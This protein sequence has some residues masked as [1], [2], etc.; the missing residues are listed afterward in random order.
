MLILN[1]DE[2][3]KGKN[4]LKTYSGE[5]KDY[6]NT[7][8]LRALAS[9]GRSAILLTIFRPGMFSKGH[10]SEHSEFTRFG[11]SDYLILAS[12]EKKEGVVLRDAVAY[13]MCNLFVVHDTILLT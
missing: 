1:C 5:S 4:V 8:S 7:T 11:V 13:Q 6:G 12:V 2:P 9:E 10:A 3:E